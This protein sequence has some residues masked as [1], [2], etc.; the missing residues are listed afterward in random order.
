MAA[1]TRRFAVRTWRLPTS[2]GASPV[3]RSGTLP[4]LRVPG[5]LC[6][7]R[8]HRSAPFARR[9]P[10]PSRHA[11]W[12]CGTTPLCPPRRVVGVRAAG[13]AASP[14]DIRPG[15]ESPPDAH[16]SSVHSRELK[17]T[18]LTD[19]KGRSTAQLGTLLIPG[20]C[21]ISGLFATVPV[22]KKRP[23]QGKLTASEESC[24]ASD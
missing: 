8:T 14:E 5:R 17:I 23:G 13:S 9:M 10:L 4:A 11:G 18:Q 7:T 2:T 6:G 1:W 22:C 12:L 24:C 21:S 15:H 19:N 20:K 3:D 16:F